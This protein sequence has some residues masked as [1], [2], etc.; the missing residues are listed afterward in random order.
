MNNEATQNKEPSA[1]NSKTLAK[2]DLEKIP[3][4]P[5]RPKTKTKIQTKSMTKYI[6]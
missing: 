2:V 5:T 3:L 1:V 4:E 6:Y